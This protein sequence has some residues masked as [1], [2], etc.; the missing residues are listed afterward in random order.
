MCSMQDKK[1]TG[2]ILKAH[3]LVLAA[4]SPVFKAEL[5]GD[6]L[7]SQTDEILIDF[8]KETMDLFLR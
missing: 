6:F 7:E 4:R 1:E 3:K 8:D 2:E 5:Y